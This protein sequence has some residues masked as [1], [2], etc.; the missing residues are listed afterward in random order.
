MR[1]AG[2]RQNRA[3]VQGQV[4]VGNDQSGVNFQ[5]VT[6]PGAARA[7][8]VWRVEREK[9][10]LNRRQG[11]LADGAGEVLGKKMV[12]KISALV[13]NGHNGDSLALPKRRFQRIRHAGTLGL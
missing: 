7:G 6:E 8:P 10:R 1:S 9:P 3:L 12:F 11:A 2:P 4:F 5:R 13:L